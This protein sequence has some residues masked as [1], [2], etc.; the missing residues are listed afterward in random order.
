MLSHNL[1]QKT[2]EWIYF[3]I[4]TTRKYLKLEFQ[5]QVFP[6]RQDRKT[7]LSVCF[8]GEVTARQFCFEI[9]WPLASQS[10]T[11]EISDLYTYQLLKIKTRE[12][13]LENSYDEN[14]LLGS[15]SSSRKC[16]T[17]WWVL[18]SRDSRFAQIENPKSDSCL[19]QKL[20]RVLKRDKSLQFSKSIWKSP[21]FGIILQKA[22]S[23]QILFYWIECTVRS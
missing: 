10:W 20:K 22:F 18:F 19:I 2:N 7:N 9:Y 16:N 11:E 17:K 12:F 8:L 1:S 6:S 13:W 21:S 15:A 5:F 3:S 4:L 23:L 14:F